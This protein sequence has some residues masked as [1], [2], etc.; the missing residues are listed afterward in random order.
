MLKNPLSGR[1]SDILPP[2]MREAGWLTRAQLESRL[3][4]GLMLRWLI[5][6]RSAGIPEDIYRLI[7]VTDDYDQA[8]QFGGEDQFYATNQHGTKSEYSLS[9]VSHGYHFVREAT[10]DEIRKYRRSGE[11]ERDTLLGNVYRC[12][13]PTGPVG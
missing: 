6:G 7:Q 5:P 2:G 11:M 9:R 1:G 12:T 13:L 10:E 8:P 4:P 3:H